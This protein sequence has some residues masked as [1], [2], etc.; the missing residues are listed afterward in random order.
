[1]KL[2][3]APVLRLLPSL[4]LCLLP[5]PSLGQNVVVDESAFRVIL[6][7]EIVGREEFSIRRVG[8]G[9]DARIIMRGSVELDLPGG[10]KNLAPALEASGEDLSPAAYQL[11]VSGS[12]T[13]EFYVSRSGRRFLA[14][15]LSSEGEQVREFR[16]G[17]GS[18]LLDTFVAHQYHQ[19][20]PYL[21]QDSAVSLSVLS[22]QSGEQ[23][24]MT[25]R[26]LGEEEVRVGTDLVQASHFRLEGENGSQ[27]IWFDERNRILKVVI[28][29]QDYTAERESIG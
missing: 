28:P 5:T 23:M 19:L 25:L 2:P 13:S 18:I 14:K 22:P 7:G 10:R 16:A 24:R 8:M 21:N 11:K 29:G 17:P 3:N 27:D 26:K 20:V 6:G 1:M 4:L 15:S 9:R 12:Q